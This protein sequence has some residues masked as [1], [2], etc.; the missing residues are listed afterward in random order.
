M[1]ARP[2]YDRKSFR[3]SPNDIEKAISFSKS[4][5]IIGRMAEWRDEKTIGLTF[6]ITPLQAVWYL[7]RRDITIR[8]GFASELGLDKA[9]FIAD[10]ARLAAG[11]ERNLRTFVKML[12]ELE[13]THRYNDSWNP[14]WKIADE[15]ADPTS[16]VAQRIRIGDTGVTWTWEALTNK[17]LE[18][19]LPTL[20]AS[21]LCGF[22]R[23]DGLWRARPHDR[24]K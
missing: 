22:S 14:N 16:V 9:R 15:I 11:R 23:S 12:V 1:D 10:Q 18:H 21:R 19:K 7:R 4:R 6:R 17:F 20:H 5:A 13:T 8:L 2:K 24:S 3:F